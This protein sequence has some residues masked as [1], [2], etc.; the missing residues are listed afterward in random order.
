MPSGGGGGSGTIIRIALQFL[1]MVRERSNRN[2][3]S[4]PTYGSTS[5]STTPGISPPSTRSQPSVDT[6]LTF[7]EYVFGGSRR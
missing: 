4:T 5:N 6:M 1:R 7:L 3:A 2:S